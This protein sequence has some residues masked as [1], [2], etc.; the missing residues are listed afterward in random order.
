MKVSARPELLVS[1][2]TPEPLTIESLARFLSAQDDNKHNSLCVSESGLIYFQSWN[3]NQKRPKFPPD[4][5]RMETFAAGNQYCGQSA[6]ADRERLDTSAFQRHPRL[7]RTWQER[8]CRL[9]VGLDKQTTNDY[10]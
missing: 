5:F 8:I 6:S 4:G 2:D 10:I 7:L 9:L 3:P 1:F